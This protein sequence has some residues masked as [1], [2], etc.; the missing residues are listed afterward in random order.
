MIQKLQDQLQ[1]S[2]TIYK[3]YTIA[4]NKHQIPLEVSFLLFVLPILTGTVDG[5]I[6]LNRLHRIMMNERRNCGII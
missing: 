4:M 6:V 5:I 2:T 1:Q 3:D